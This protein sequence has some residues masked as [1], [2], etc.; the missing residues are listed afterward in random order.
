MCGEA[1]FEAEGSPSRVAVCHCRYCQ[2]RTG[3]A[4]GISVYFPV[5]KIKVISGSFEDYS[6]E[7][8]SGNKAKIE[9]CINCGTSLFWQIYADTHSGIKGTAGGAY[10][11]PSFW[12]D[13]Q[14]EVFT[15]TRAE[16]CS[17]DA[18]NSYNTHPAYSPLRGDE[19]R[20]S[21]DQGS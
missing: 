13:L 12:Y 8:E 14:R 11:P 7:T 17:I 3:S 16:F 2:L 18:V 9:R 15:R 19:P 5:N 4:F 20:L 6:Y 10:D 1:R 21:G